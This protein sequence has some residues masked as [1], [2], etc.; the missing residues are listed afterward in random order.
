MILAL[1]ELRRFELL[2]SCM[3]YTFQPSLSVAWRGPMR[4]LPAA[5]LAGCG[6][7]SPG[8]W[9]RWLPTWLPGNLLALLMFDLFEH[10]RTAGRSSRP[11]ADQS[12][13]L[14]GGLLLT[15]AG[16]LMA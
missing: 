8:V 1:V 11:R 4:C 12:F 5:T 10:R 2:T 14:T 13:W 3:P 9:R 15:M 16:C 6:Q 7:T